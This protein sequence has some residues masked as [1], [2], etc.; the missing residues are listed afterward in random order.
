MTFLMFAMAPSTGGGGTGGGMG[1]G[2]F[3]PMVLVFVIFYFLIL[4]PQ[5][6]RQK[7]HEKMLNTLVKGDQ[8][9][10]SG[11]IHGTVQRVNEKELTLI[12]KIA[13]D[14]KIEV[15]RAAVARKVL[16]GTE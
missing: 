8:V 6:K 4:R 12:L 11:G 13:D 2:A 15:D 16:S 14:V 3:L 7:E 1:I 10:T 9:V 5:S